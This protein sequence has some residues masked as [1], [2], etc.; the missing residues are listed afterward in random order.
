VLLNIVGNAITAVGPT[1]T[2][3]FRS[4]VISSFTIATRRHPLVAAIE[5]KDDGPGVPND[6]RDQIFYPMVSG[7]DMGTGLGLSIAQSIINQLGGLIECRSEPG[8]TIFT[9]LIPLE[10]L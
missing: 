9:V 7:T 6:I 1:G 2:I 8:N 10:M 3:T 5:I 4:R